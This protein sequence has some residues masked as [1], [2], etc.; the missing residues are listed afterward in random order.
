MLL[1]LGVTELSVL[2]ALA[3]PLFLVRRL[4]K[5]LRSLADRLDNGAHQVQ[6]AAAQ[7]SSASQESASGA[8]EQASS[9]EETSAAFEQMAAMTRTSADNARQACELTG[10]ARTAAQIGDH[11]MVQLNEAMD[12]ISESSQKISKIIRVIEEITFQTNLLALNAAVEAA[13]AGEHGKGFAVVADK[14]RTLA[15]RAAQAAQE[16]AGL[17]GDSVDKAQSGAAIAGE[18]GKALSGIVTDVTK[19]SDLIDRISSSSQEQA[20]GVDQMNTAAHELAG[21]ASG[22]MA[23]VDE[24]A[25]IV[26]GTGSSAAG[27]KS[28]ATAR[29]TTCG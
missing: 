26:G 27:S 14:V 7:V 2:M 9:L 28:K 22:L 12:G 25:A 16:T 18:V 8:S 20:Q 17:T 1:I 23:V 11:T 13:R 24:L 5:L 3:T 21:Q 19:V 10:A 4:S 29:Q 15:L 6:G